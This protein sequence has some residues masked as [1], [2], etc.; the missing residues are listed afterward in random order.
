MWETSGETVEH[1]VLGERPREERRA[2]ARLRAPALTVLHHPDC[3]RV[4]ER[5]LLGTVAAGWAASLSRRE[6]VF[7]P[8]D[9]LG[10]QPL[11]DRHLSRSPLRLVPGAEPGGV[12]LEVGAS[13]VHLVADGVPVQQDRELSAGEVARG[14]VLELAG[15]IVLLL[16]PLA[17]TL[18]PEAEGFGLVGASDAMAQVRREIAR[19]ADLGVPVLLRGETGTGKELAARAIHQAS[20][21]RGGACVCVNLGAIPASL[22]AS[23]LFGAAKGAF[24]GAERKAGYFQRAHGG[25]LFLDE[26]GDAPAEVQVALLRVLETGE[27]QRVG[28]EE[29]QRVDV[30]LI[31]GTD[32]DLEAAIRDGRFREAL[33]HRLSGYEIPIPP[34]R[35]RRDD[36]GRLLYSFLRQ[37][38][39]ALGE[40]DRLDP[41][42]QEG[43]PWMPASI[44][45]RLARHPWPGNVRQLRNVA[46]QLVIGS[47]GSQSVVVGPQ[48]ERL[49]R[50]AATPAGPVPAAG[51]EKRHEETTPRRAPAA[52][53]RPAEVGEEELLAALRANR[54]ELKPTAAQLGIA[55]PSLYLLIARSGQVRKA[56][57]LSRAEILECHGACGGDLEAMVDHLEVSQS[58]LAQRMRQLGIG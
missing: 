45:A 34:L 27:V 48:V 17:A 47:R 38:L 20:R 53:R 43:E 2:Q 10:G 21:R 49:L 51:P 33:L 46:R 11:G 28:A 8:P 57:D 19:V 9:G 31:A 39:A 22:A 12:R 6:P 26:I 15:R 3:R 55:R 40:V 36:V 7:S 54:W 58:G 29:P 56:A 4:G 42:P 23:E 14:V 37:E 52:W 18:P 32:A 30:R 50:E 5:A 16:H 25:T 24:T 35:E 13:P 44:V 1:F 41:P